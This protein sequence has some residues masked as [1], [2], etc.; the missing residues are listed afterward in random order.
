MAQ[1]ISMVNVIRALIIQLFKGS[2]NNEYGWLRKCGGDDTTYL[3]DRFQSGSCQGFHTKD[4][5]KYTP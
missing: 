5:D 2:T 3:S 4:L 1:Y